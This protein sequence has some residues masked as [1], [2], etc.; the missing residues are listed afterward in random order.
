[1]NIERPLR[2]LHCPEMVGGHPQQLAKAE[3]AL[4][5]DSW[6]LVWSVNRFDY[7]CDEVLF[8][9]DASRWRKGWGRFTLLTRALLRFDVIH[10]NFGLSLIPSTNPNTQSLWN[11]LLGGFELADLPLLKFAGKT[12]VFTFQGDDA[13]Q[14][15]RLEQF[16]KFDWRQ[17]FGAD[18]YSP[19]TDAH[20]RWRIDKI[21]RWADRIYALNPDLL[22]VLPPTAQFSPYAHVDV[23]RYSLRTPPKNRVPLVMH[24]PSHRG[25]KGT[26]YIV[27]AVARLRDEGIPFDFELVEGKTHAEAMERYRQADL[28][29]DQLLLGWY[30]GVAVECMALGVP[31]VSYVR[32]W[33]LQQTPNA[34]QAELPVIGADQ[35]SVYSVLK[36]WLTVR[37]AELPEVGRRSRKFVE[38]WHNP[39]AIARQVADDYSHLRT[40]SRRAG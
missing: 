14:G 4:G 11:R 25:V 24:A 13:R 5:L 2:V 28:M 39:K 17:E 19:Q 40:R 38:T 36:E 34:M 1:V 23:D 6:S 26:R 16:A 3:R 32:P 7:S 8:S 20:K 15:D 21:A 33:D 30:G 35:H 22:R 27:E 12:I 18:Y 9:D 37:R 31:V 10:F 29:I